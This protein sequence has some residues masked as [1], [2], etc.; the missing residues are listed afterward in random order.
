MSG[1]ESERS[2]LDLIRQLKA[3]VINGKALSR[4]ERQLCVE[5]LLSEGYTQ[6]KLAAIFECTDRTIRNDLEVIRERNALTPSVDFMRKTVGLLYKTMLSHWAALTRLGRAENGTVTERAYAESLAWRVV[7]E[8]FEK[9]QSVGYLPCRPHEVVGDIYHHLSA[10]ETRHDIEAMKSLVVE[11]EKETGESGGFLP[12]VA[13]R[14]QQ[15]KDDL[16]KEE[17]KEQ[18]KELKQRQK[19]GG[20]EEKTGA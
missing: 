12:E 18:L 8:G 15:L 14:L 5:V 9:L 4:E 2:A 11:F 20:D 13:E 16:R 6:A 19:E 1:H 10:G 3:G 7:K 17:M